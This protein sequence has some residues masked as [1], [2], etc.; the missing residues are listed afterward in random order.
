MTPVSCACSCLSGLFE[1]L[2]GGDGPGCAASTPR[3]CL[4]Q[5]EQAQLPRTPSH[6]TEAKG[7]EEWRES[8]TRGG[9]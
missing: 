5:K 7:S 4:P 3:G 9:G 8:R 1:T 2:V 6:V